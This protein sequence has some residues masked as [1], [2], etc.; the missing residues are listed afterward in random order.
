MIEI[1]NHSKFK[2]SPDVFSEI[3]DNETVLLDMKSENYF[4]L[5]EVGSNI[6]VLLKEGTDI[7]SV[8]YDLMQI[9]DVGKGQLEKDIS[10]LFEELQNAGLIELIT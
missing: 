6:L 2:L 5:N 3:I 9:Y 10:G 7:E 4:G 8:I 1:N